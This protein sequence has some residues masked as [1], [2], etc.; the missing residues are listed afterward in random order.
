[1]EFIYW[2]HPSIPCIKIEEVSGGEEYSGKVWLEMARQVYAE[3]GREAYRDIG[4]FKNG[5]PFL[6]GENSRIS[7]SHCPGLFIVATL[8]PTPECNLGEFSERA[9]M[10]IDAER[11]DRA[12]VLK[13]RERF[14]APE[15]L[16]LIDSENLEANIIAWTIKEAAYKT[17]LVE[18]LDFRRSIRIL[19]LPRLAP[20]TPVFDPV[21]YGLPPTQKSLPA[22]FFGEVH[23]TVGE[24][25]DVILTVYSYKSDEHIVTLCYSPKCAKF[26]P[27][28][29]K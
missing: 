6:F 25:E 17:M 18:G 8:P 15:E 14:L 24:G 27:F 22:D 7:I 5:A 11:E 29:R 12:Q 10:G 23:V 1:M 28:L 4:H 2:R 26:G 3:N 21:E 19:R 13:I 9:A 20:P 16:E